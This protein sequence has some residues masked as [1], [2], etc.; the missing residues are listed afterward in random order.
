M[1]GTHFARVAS[2]SP[3]HDNDW[4]QRS[5]G[6]LIDH[7]VQQHHAYLRREL[8]RLNR[9][10]Q[11]CE[12]ASPASMPTLAALRGVL[13]ALTDELMQ[14]M[15]KEEMVLFPW[16]RQLTNSGPGKI[17]AAHCGTIGAPI[18]VMEHEHAFA[19]DALARLR[20]LT[21]SYT[22][23]NCTDDFRAVLAGL[24]ALDADLQEH[25]HEENDILFPRALELESRQH[26][27][28]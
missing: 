2:H 15:H 24:S 1:S 17:G 7:I 26:A 21:D 8:P 9:A 19:N 4:S 14:H 11:Q 27:G 25:I 5:L 10:A 18:Q 13:H 23:N 28:A 22:P 3:E 20:Q 16:I 6:A 12:A